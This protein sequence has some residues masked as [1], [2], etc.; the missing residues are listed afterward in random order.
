MEKRGNSILVAGITPYFLERGDL[1]FKENEQSIQQ[2]VKNDQWW[3]DHTLFIEV[4]ERIP[5]SPFVR[6]VTDL[7]YAKVSTIEHRGEFATRGGIIDIFPI[8]REEPVRIDFSG[9]TIE[10]I[11]PF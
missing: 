4:G 8:N 10:A 7:G 3:R 5:F 6:K 1:W 2:K 9:N 11:H